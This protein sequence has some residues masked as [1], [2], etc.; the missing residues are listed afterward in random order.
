MD[1]DTAILFTP[2]YS[3]MQPIE[4]K[5]ILEVIRNSQ[6]KGLVVTI[7]GSVDNDFCEFW[8]PG[9]LGRFTSGFRHAAVIKDYL[10]EHFSEYSS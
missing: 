8:P 4:D 6:E 9:E 10:S 1:Q 5:K 7:I 3:S 2:I